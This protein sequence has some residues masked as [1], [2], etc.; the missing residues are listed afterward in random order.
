MAILDLDSPR[1]LFGSTADFAAFPDRP[2]H[3]PHLT[4]HR[5][6]TT[7]VTAQYLIA[8]ASVSPDVG[9]DCH[10]ADVLLKMGTLLRSITSS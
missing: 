2:S 9:T 4:F 6:L 7:A 10:T 8:K 1:Y 3:T 5:M